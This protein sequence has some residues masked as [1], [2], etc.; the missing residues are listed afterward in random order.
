MIYRRLIPLLFCAL[1]TIQAGPALYSIGLDTHTLSG[2]YYLD[3]V[4]IGTAGNTVALNSFQFGGGTPGANSTI[5]NPLPLGASG[6]YTSGIALN[7]SLGFVVEF[8]QA[9][10]PGA[11]LQFQVLLDNNPPLPGDFPDT[12][13][14]S[15]LDSGLNTIPT[16]DL[17]AS[18]LFSVDL[19]G[20]S[21]VPTIS[22]TTG[23][24]GGIAPVVVPEPSVFPV[25]FLA[26][27]IAIRRRRQRQS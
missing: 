7:D 2:T 23:P 10:T 3:F 26:A 11:S 8:Y 19:T 13:S 17:D 27:V 21:P 15:L 9:F 12:F 25:T 20:G 22:S 5:I 16:T 18:T 6:D 14:F 24:S 1:G 4:L